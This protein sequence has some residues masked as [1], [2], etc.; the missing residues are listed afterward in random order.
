M[1]HDDDRSY[2]PFQPYTVFIEPLTGDG[3]TPTGI[4]V[5]HHARLPRVLGLVTSCH[6]TVAHRRP[7]I[8]PGTVVV[9]RQHAYD[10]ADTATGITLYVL[11]IDNCRAILDFESD[12]DDDCNAAQVETDS[13][14]SHQLYTA[15]I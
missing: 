2:L 15:T 10:E 9:F 3:F 6:P 1:I 14:T 13:A 5:Q 7:E 12:T 4:E 8:V 11:H